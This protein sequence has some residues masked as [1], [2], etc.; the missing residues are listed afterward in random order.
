MRCR[1]L[2]AR[3]KVF[4]AFGG[5]LGSHLQY[6]SMKHKKNYLASFDL[7]INVCLCYKMIYDRDTINRKSHLSHTRTC[8]FDVGLPHPLLR[9]LKTPINIKGGVQTSSSFVQISISIPEP[10]F[11]QSGI[12]G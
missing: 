7:H 9:Y 3:D 11:T 10:I 4:C 1:R 5:H 2:N 6:C 12:F 8:C